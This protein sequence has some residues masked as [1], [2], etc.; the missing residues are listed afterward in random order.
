MT[1]QLERVT[2]FKRHLFSLEEYERMVEAGIFGPEANLELI[3]GEIIEMTPPGPAHEASVARLH[4]MFAKLVSD[5]VLIWPQGNAIR[6][7]H[8]K[9]RPQ[10]DIALLRWRDDYYVNKRPFPEDVILLIE[11]SDSTLKFDRGSKLELYAEAGVPEYWVVNL[12]EN[13]VEVY[14][15]PGG[16]KYQLVM[17]YKRGE[18]LELPG[19]L[20]G[21][22]AVDDVVG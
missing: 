20:E 16:G 2:G 11:V 4:R 3:Q 19:G 12:V 14:S 7:P 18:T 13:V 21:S 17:K 1:L 6:L 22:I 8:S 5:D 9:S 15:D 10:P